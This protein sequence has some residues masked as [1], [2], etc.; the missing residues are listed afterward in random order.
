MGKDRGE[1]RKLVEIAAA[2]CR[3]VSDLWRFGEHLSGAMHLMCHHTTSI[4]SLD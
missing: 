2:D 4:N 3:D 1:L